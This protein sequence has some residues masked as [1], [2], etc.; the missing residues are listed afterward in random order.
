[1]RVSQMDSSVV[2]T[3]WFWT[4]PE[5]RGGLYA[6]TAYAIMCLFTYAAWS[7]ENP[8]EEFPDANVRGRMTGGM[9]M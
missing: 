9:Y 7:S 6:W 3:S 4:S 8:S 1:M 5:Y 2:V